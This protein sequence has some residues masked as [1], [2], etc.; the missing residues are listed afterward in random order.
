MNVDTFDTTYLLY[1]NNCIKSLRMKHSILVTLALFF[2]CSLSYSQKDETSSVMDCDHSET[3][4]IKRLTELDFPQANSSFEGIPDS[5]AQSIID[6][7]KQ[8]L[9]TPYRR[10]TKGPK[11][12]DC[13]GFTSFIF[14]K[15]GYRLSPACVVQANEGTKVVK[16][17][18]KT[19]DLVFVKGRNAKSNRVGH[20]GIVVSNDGSGNISFIHACRRGV[21]ID[22]LSQSGYYQPR[23]ITGLRISET[24][25]ETQAKNDKPHS[26]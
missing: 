12:F 10:G 2:V 1:K 11:T 5:I 8:F 20:V 19:G 23:Y 24:K 9:G 14:K 4:E 13:S 17:E 18:L 21:V 25:K 3:K 6:Y 7:S 26:I 16:E 22:E 15:F